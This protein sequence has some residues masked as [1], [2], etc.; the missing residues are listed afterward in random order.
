[1]D[2]GEEVTAGGGE[3]AQIRERKVGEGLVNT[4][5]WQLN[6]LNTCTMLFT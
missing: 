4:H 6:H 2:E 3:S 5:C 1:M